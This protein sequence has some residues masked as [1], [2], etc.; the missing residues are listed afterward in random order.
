MAET[1]VRTA[2]TRVPATVATEVVVV[3]LRRATAVRAVG[4]EAVGTE[5][6]VIRARPVAV[7][8]IPLEEAVDTPL[9][10]VAG[11]PVVAAA[12]TPEAAIAKR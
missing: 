6:A 5:A 4:T 9:A 12:D 2:D 10:V 3:A 7:A 8:G 1:R 11:T